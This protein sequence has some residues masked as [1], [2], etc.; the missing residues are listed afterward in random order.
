MTEPVI[1]KDAK[2]HDSVRQMRL[3]GRLDF[4]LREYE[5]KAGGKSHPATE[6]WNVSWQAADAARTEYVLTP[7]LVDD[8][9]IALG[10][11]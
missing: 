9:R 6:A 7:E 5:G 2:T 8:V 10:R 1:E 4:Y 3:A 11:L